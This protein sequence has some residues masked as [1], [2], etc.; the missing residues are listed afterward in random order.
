MRRSLWLF[1]IT[2]LAVPALQ[3]CERR[4]ETPPDVAQAFRTLLSSLDPSAPGAS[5]ARLQEFARRNSRYVIASAVDT[6]VK[7]WRSRLDPAYLRGR[8]LVRE[9]QFDRAEAVLKDL[10][11]LP[12]EKAG[13]LSRGF[14]AFE[15]PQM[16]ATRLLQKG[17]TAGAEAVLKTLTR[18]D[19]SE[20]QMAAAQRLLD[21]ANVVGIGA[22]MT[23][24]TAMKSAA[25]ALHVYLLSSYMDNGQYPAALTLGS[26]ELA[27]LRSGGPLL[28]VVASIDDYRATQ[29]P[30]SLVLTGKDPRQRIRITQTGIEE[31]PPPRQP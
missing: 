19:L 7:A 27:S 12:D 31:I 10:A 30:F 9:E 16:K 13:R 14:L 22:V 20:E 4:S 24:T 29:D 1:I 11:R 18:A 26:P 5:L 21:S 2:M 3:G 15:F 17:D 23:R 8:D 6:E 28:D 25:R